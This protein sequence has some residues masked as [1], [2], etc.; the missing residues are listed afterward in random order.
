MKRRMKREFHVRCCEGLVVESHRPTRR[1]HRPTRQ[2]LRRGH[3]ITAVV[4]TPSKVA[5]GERIHAVKSDLSD[6]KL[7]ADAF[8]GA[9]VVVSAYGTLLRITQMN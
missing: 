5:K 9:E 7:I 6:V 3:N 2:L 1:S 8:K 4:R